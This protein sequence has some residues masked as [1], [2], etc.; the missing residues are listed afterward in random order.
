[1]Y[2]R[3]HCSTS[4]FSDEKLAAAWNQRHPWRF[5]IASAVEKTIRKPFENSGAGYKALNKQH[6]QAYLLYVEDCCLFS[7]AVDGVHI[8][9]SLVKFESSRIKLIIHTLLLQQTF[10]RTA[11]DNFAVV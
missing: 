8:F 9:K 2:V 10:M 7:N 5:C 11:L 6:P 1:M 4:S 3:V